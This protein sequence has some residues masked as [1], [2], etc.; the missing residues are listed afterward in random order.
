MI[1]P[2]RYQEASFNMRI[3]P[4]KKLFWAYIPQEGMLANSDKV[5]IHGKAVRRFGRW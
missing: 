5:A 2:P 4:A 3:Q 1:T